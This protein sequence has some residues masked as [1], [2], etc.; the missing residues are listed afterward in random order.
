MQ[1]IKIAALAV[2]CAALGF[3]GYAAYA[4]HGA[5]VR[6]NAALQQVSA[7]LD[8]SR[9]VYGTVR[10]F[11]KTLDLLEFGRLGPYEYGE[12]AI[13]RLSLL[14]GALV[15]RQTLIG[16]NA[17]YAGVSSTTPVT[18]DLA[19]VLV[20][21]AHIKAFVLTPRGGGT[22]TIGYLLVGDPL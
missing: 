7:S 18:E 11:D 2:L 4:Y 1:P 9:A 5:Y 12:P 17:V 3:A 6:A 19:K 13:E 10:S 22:P 15:S 21:G 14:P 16:S 20:P 8:T